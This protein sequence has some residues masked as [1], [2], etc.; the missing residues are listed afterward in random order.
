M[1]SHR[2]LHRRRNRSHRRSPVALAAAG[3]VV[4]AGLLGAAA[5]ASGDDD[6]PDESRRTTLVIELPPGTANADPPPG[7]DIVRDIVAEFRPALAPV[8]AHL[9]LLVVDSANAATASAVEIPG[10]VDGALDTASLNDIARSNDIDGLEPAWIDFVD[11]LLTET[12]PLDGGR[13]LLGAIRRAQRQDP[14]RIVLITTSGGLHRGAD[15]DWVDVASTRY[16]GPEIDLS[17]DDDTSFLITGVG[18]IPATGS[19]IP[20]VELTTVVVDAWDAWCDL[21]Q[22]CEVRS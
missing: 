4:G 1:T 2:Q 6:P 14:D 21:Q 10:T 12:E 7:D 20:P 3:L 13:D 17:L 11:E 18:D 5:F 22:D 9:T 8:G 16:A 15:A 19:R